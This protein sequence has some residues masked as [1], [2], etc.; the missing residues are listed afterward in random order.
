[1]FSRRIAICCGL[2][3][4]CL[5]GLY[6]CHVHHTAGTGLPSDEEMMANFYAHRADFEELV[7]RWREHP[8]VSDGK[9]IGYLFPRENAQQMK[10]AGISRIN[11]SIPFWYPDPYSIQ[12]AQK[13]YDMAARKNDPVYGFDVLHKYREAVIKPEHEID[14]Y[15]KS[16]LIRANNDVRL[17]MVWKDFVHMPEVPRIENG[18][19]LNPPSVAS[20]KIAPDDQYHEKENVYVQQKRRRVLSS[21]NTIPEDWK[22]NEC[23]YRQLEPQWFLQMCNGR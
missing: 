13:R 22:V 12:T 5:F 21:L 15:T 11:E 2:V 9:G 3:V 8:P 6:R 19:L 18:W 14:R 16:R 4:L 17:S 10:R 23:V 7:W 20:S 1:M